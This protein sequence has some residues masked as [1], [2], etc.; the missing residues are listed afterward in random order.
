MDIVP[1]HSEEHANQYHSKRTKTQ[2]F[3]EAKPIFHA[4]S[5]IH[6][7]KQGVWT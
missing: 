4:R 3:E 5:L 2:Y 6:N 7:K 1:Q